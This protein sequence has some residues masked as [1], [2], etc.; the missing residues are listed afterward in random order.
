MMNTYDPN[1][2]PVPVDWL[3]L[4]EQERMELAEA[5]H[6]AADVD[7]PHN[8]R[9]HAVVHTVVE[10]QLAM[11]EPAGVQ[12]TLRRLLAAGVDR[13]SAIHA[14]GSVLVEYL[15]DLTTG[16]ADAQN[17]N[18]RYEKSLERVDEHEW[19]AS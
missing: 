9:L 14:I 18:E 2:A 7:A 17:V 12:R 1:Q 8:E 11:G 13:H 3:H 16:Q 10:N 15:H 5:Y 19:G 4:D 6:R